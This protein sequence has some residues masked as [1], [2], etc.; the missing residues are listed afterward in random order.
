MQQSGSNSSDSTSSAGVLKGHVPEYVQGLMQERMDS[1]DW[2]LHELA[3]CVAAIS[4]LIDEEVMADLRFV[5]STVLQF[6]T[7]SDLNEW[8]YGSVVDVYLAQ[9]ILD[10]NWDAWRSASR[11]K[12]AGSIYVSIM[13]E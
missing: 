8:E 10:E 5:Y 7:T 2:G 6:S 12:E 3:L 1:Q 9:Y 13:K 11:M 4:Q